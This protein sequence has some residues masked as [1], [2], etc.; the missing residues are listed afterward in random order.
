MDP[1]FS[2]ILFIGPTSLT[3]TLPFR[4]LL[5]PSIQAGHGGGKPTAKI[6]DEAV[7]KWGWGSRQIGLKMLE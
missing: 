1:L 4:F 2:T 7:D 5:L 3:S 6:I